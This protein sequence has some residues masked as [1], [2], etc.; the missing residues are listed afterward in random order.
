MNPLQSL[1]KL[2]AFAFLSC[3]VVQAASAQDQVSLDLNYDSPT[4]SISSISYTIQ[5][6]DAAYDSE[7]SDLYDKAGSWFLG[8]EDYTSTVEILDAEGSLIKIR[9]DLIGSGS[10]SGTGKVADAMI[11][12]LVSIDDVHKNRSASA[13]VIDT[14]IEVAEIDITVYPNPATDYV[15]WEGASSTEGSLVQVISPNGKTQTLP[16]EAGK[17]LDVSTWPRGFYMLRFLSEGTAVTRKLLL[18]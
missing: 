12:V 15:K 7:A 5:L 18:N 6:E 3:I 9:F 8:N 10:K 14:E 2:L 13:T 1:V 4:Q 11:G 17:A 16:W